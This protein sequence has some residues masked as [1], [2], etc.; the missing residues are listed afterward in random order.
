[1]EM[2]ALTT[3]GSNETSIASAT[4]QAQA[5]VQA[6]YVMAMQRPRMMDQVRV[7]I[8][9]ECKRPKFAEGAKYNKPIGKGIEGPSIRYVEAALRCMGNILTETPTIY[10]DSSK[11]I[12]RVIVT[13]L[14]SNTTYQKDVTVTKT[15]ERTSIK[16]NQPYLSSRLNSYGKTTYTVEATDD[17]ILNKEGALISK[18]IRTLGLRIIPGDIVEESMEMVEKVQNNEISNAPEEARKKLVD[19]FASL[20]VHPSDLVMYLKHDLA[21]CTPAELAKLR[22]IY[23][24]LANGE[25]VWSDYV[26]TEAPQSE[27]STAETEQNKTESSELKDLLGRTKKK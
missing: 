14:E 10:D 2:T 3:T 11:R 22:K 18:A 26:S 23:V 4:A 19:G 5:S 17:D 1:M 8:L 27:S 21:K 9:N 6:R 16:D 24:T 15:V 20:N 25:A 12:V 7:N 13:D